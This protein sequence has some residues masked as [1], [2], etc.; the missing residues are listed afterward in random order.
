MIIKQ[1]DFVLENC[2]VISIPGYYI[3]FIDI[4]DIKTNISR[5][6]C[7]CVME[8]KVCNDF[9][10][11]IHRDAN[12]P[13]YPFDIHDERQNYTVFDR[14]TSWKD[15]TQIEITLTDNECYE[16]NFDEHLEKHTIY[17]NWSGNNEYENA[18]QQC[19]INKSGDLY[20]TVNENKKPMYEVF[21]EE[22]DDLEHVDFHFEFLDVGDDNHKSF[23]ELMK[24]Y[25]D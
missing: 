19:Y 2:E 25:S 4:S 24:K 9:A 14:F 22:I 18:G 10:V 13:Y 1:I 16:E 3:G 20:I 15:I 17:L 21:G 23:V 7:N 12:K 5:V 8:M 11:E 6:A